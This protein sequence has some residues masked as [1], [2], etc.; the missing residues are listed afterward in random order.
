MFLWDFLVWFYS[1]VIWGISGGSVSARV[2]RSGKA[3]RGSGGRIWP[4]S[5]G[6]WGEWVS[7]GCRIWPCP[8]ASCGG[9]SLG[10][11]PCSGVQDHVLG[12]KAL[13]YSKRGPMGAGCG[14]I[15]RGMSVCVGSLGCSI[16]P[17]RVFVWGC[18][19]A[20][21]G[22]AGCEVCVG[23]VLPCSPAG[24]CGE[25]WEFFG[26]RI[27]PCCTLGWVCGWGGCPPWCG[28]QP[29]P[30]APWVESPRGAGCGRAA[31]RGCVSPQCRIL[32]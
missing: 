4:C 6:P 14:P 5:V 28:I 26:C 1:A 32:P 9:G 30:T 2:S 13:G 29:C 15:L 25:G 12:C 16:P 24:Q 20:A 17:C 19:G 11:G 22:P 3:P 18:W 10:A 23:G 21:S 27:W 8:V 7:P 31:P